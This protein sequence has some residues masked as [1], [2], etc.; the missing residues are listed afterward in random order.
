MSLY[1]HFS[2]KNELFDLV[3]AELTRRLYADD[4]APTTWQ[5]DLF[6]LCQHV[7]EVLVAHARWIPLLAR[8]STPLAVPIRE[9]LLGQ[10]VR[11]GMTAESA[12]A[13]LTSALMTT[14]GLVL[15]DTSLR[16]PDGD[17][18]M[19]K[20]YERLRAWAES[21][22]DFEEALTKTALSKQRHLDLEAN[23]QLAIQ[24]LI[25]GLDAN[26][27]GVSSGIAV[28]TTG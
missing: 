19:S 6:M 24:S 1:T 12:M 21:A 27:R 8:P 14:I 23:F 17:A 7:R 28:K 22:P 4:H 5:S 26:R 25:T 18:A 20:R 10:M 11:D 3:Y 9:R 16:E 13:A 15:V 2:N